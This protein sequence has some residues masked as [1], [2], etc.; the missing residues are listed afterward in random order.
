M[1]TPPWMFVST[2]LDIWI[3]IKIKSY[4][5]HLKA[6]ISLETKFGDSFYKLLNK[7]PIISANFLESFY[8]KFKALTRKE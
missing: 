1:E 8:V 6:K 4:K 5:V 2:T 7:T 3:C